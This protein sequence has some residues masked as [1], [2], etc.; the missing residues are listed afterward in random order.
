MTRHRSMLLLAALPAALLLAGA[1]S[2]QD[3]GSRQTR[4][5][6]QAAAESDTFELMEA[7][8]ALAESKDPQVR[9]FAQHMLEA[10]H[11]TAQALQQAAARSGLKPP[12]MAVG[13]GDSPL[14]AA[15]QSARG[16]AFDRAYW[17]QQ[18]LAHRAAL[19]TAQRYAANGDDPAVRQAATALVPIIS[20]HLAMAEQHAQAG[21]GE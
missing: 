5:F 6:V 21:G 4:E 14:L 2:A 19:V 1:A 9:A 16:A 7:S 15:L 3:P 13:A 17:R 11:G 10:H 8:T 20:S 12:V 18:A